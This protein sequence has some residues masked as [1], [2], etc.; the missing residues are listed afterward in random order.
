MVQ[1]SSGA[2]HWLESAQVDD[3]TGDTMIPLGL[4]LPLAQAKAFN[5]GSADLTWIVCFCFCCGAR[6]ALATQA[7]VQWH[8]ALQART[9]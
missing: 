6:A 9:C 1:I 3:E 7:R 8:P 5:G 4:P 2:A